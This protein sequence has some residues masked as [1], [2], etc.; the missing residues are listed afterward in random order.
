MQMKFE[1]IPFIENNKIQTAINSSGFNLPELNENNSWL[2]F[3]TA[4]SSLKVYVHFGYYENMTGCFL[5]LNNDTI[6]TFKEGIF[7]IKLSSFLAQ[8]PEQFS[9]QITNHFQQKMQTVFFAHS[10]YVNECLRPFLMRCL[11]L[12][13]SLPRSILNAFEIECAAGIS[14]TEGEALVKKRIGQEKFRAGLV[15]FWK[16]QCAISG[17]EVVELLK[18]SHIKPWASCENN[19]ER[20]SVFNGLLLSPNLDAAFDKGFF[21]FNEEKK[22]VV[23]NK[24]S[25]EVAT[26][27]SIPKFFIFSAL[28]SNHLKFFEWHRKYVFKNTD[29]S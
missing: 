29:N 12:S 10:I 22:I 18:A 15:E 16:G 21:T 5:F 25:C 17:L 20:L 14:Q 19:E 28:N 23:S 4:L 27:L 7:P 8:I 24:I 26:E 11:Q 6:S 9:N 1:Q 3:A 13:L 2:I